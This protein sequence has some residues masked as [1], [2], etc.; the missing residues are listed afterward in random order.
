M[1]SFW[2]SFSISFL[3]RSAF[4]GYLLILSYALSLTSYDSIYLILTNDKIKIITDNTSLFLIIS[5]FAGVTIN[6]LHR[7]AIYPIFEFI[8]DSD[9]AED[10]RNIE[11]CGLHIFRGISTNS[12][13]FMINYWKIK[14]K[15]KTQ[16]WGDNTHLIYISG[17]SL[18]IG[19]LIGGNINNIINKTTS[20]TIKTSYNNIINTTIS[21]TGNSIHS[22]NYNQTILCFTLPIICWLGI[23]VYAF[24]FLSDWR[25]K[26][27]RDK[28]MQDY[29]ISEKGFFKE[30]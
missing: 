29:E 20:T 1:E 3:L 21:I 25:L 24:G 11:I 15:E 2:K 23:L 6:G 14:N 13:N 16:E 27:V 7:A 19:G 22:I 8:K 5:L 18:F 12:T 17:L 30:K 26:F 28:M 4:S 10:F 9:L